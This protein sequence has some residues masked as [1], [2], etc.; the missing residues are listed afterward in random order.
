MI[1]KRLCIC[2]II[3]EWFFIVLFYQ[4]SQFAENK[5]NKM[6]EWG[7]RREKNEKGFCYS[8]FVIFVPRKMFFTCSIF[9]AIHQSIRRKNPVAEITNF[10]RKC[11][12]ENKKKIPNKKKVRNKK[13]FRISEKNLS[14]VFQ[15]LQ[16]GPAAQDHEDDRNHDGKDGNACQDQCNHGLLLLLLL[17]LK[18]FP[19]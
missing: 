13:I 14:S 4:F 2:L 16:E 6:K 17:S 5:K 8:N 7:K 19:F 11:Y 3:I 1:V 9:R 10:W 18:P 15:L 12:C